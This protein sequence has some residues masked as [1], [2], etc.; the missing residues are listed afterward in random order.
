MDQIGDKCPKR[1]TLITETARKRWNSRNP[2]STSVCQGHTS[3]LMDAAQQSCD[4]AGVWK[5]KT[6]SSGSIKLRVNVVVLSVF[7]YFAAGIG[8]MGLT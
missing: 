3:R 2:V 6:L 7:V 8:K 4:K 1:H 5:G